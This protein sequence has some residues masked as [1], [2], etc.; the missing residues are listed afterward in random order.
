MV[1]LETFRDYYRESAWTWEHMALTRSRIIY[2][3]SE[4]ARYI[5]D[6]ISGVLTRKRDIAALAATVAEMR[7]KL[8][9]A[10]GKVSCWNLKEV[11]GGLVDIEFICQYVTLKNGASNPGI[12]APNINDGLIRL[13]DVGVLSPQD[14][15]TLSNAHILMQKLQSIIRLCFGV[16]KPNED[17]FSTSFKDSACRVCGIDKFETLK[18]TLLAN[19]QAVLN[20]FDK[21]IG[22]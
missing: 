12:F 18:Q 13:K 16:E 4:V 8:A 20:V 15:E 5:E 10:S 19:Q 1:T 21:T 22:V 7:E 9:A 11:R 14:L 2:A 6:T 3:P 17:D